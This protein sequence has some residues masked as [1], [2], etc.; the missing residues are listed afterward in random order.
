MVVTADHGVSFRAGQPRRL[1]THENFPDIASVPMFV[2]APGQAEGRVDDSPVRTIDV[3]PTIADL[4]ELRSGWDFDGR[5]ARGRD[6][7]ALHGRRS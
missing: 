2:K 3:L 6:Q 1:A 4:L 7:R 5:S